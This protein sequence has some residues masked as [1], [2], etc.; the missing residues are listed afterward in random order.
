MRKYDID[1]PDDWDELRIELHCISKGGRWTR[2]N[3][4]EAGL[5][6]FEHLM[7]ARKLAWPDRYR[8]RWTDLLYAEYV[9]NDITIA[10]GAAST[11]KTS[12]ASEFALLNYWARPNNTLVILST[13]SMDKLDTGVFSEVKML[14]QNAHTLYPWLAGNLLESR[15]AITTD[16]VDEGGVRDLRKGII[17]RACYVGGRWVG[18]GVL[19]GTKQ[20]YIIYLADELQFMAETFIASWP[21]LFSNGHVKILGSGNPKHDPD[22]QLGIA[23]EPKEGWTGAQGDITKTDVWDTQF[24]NGRCVNLVGIDSPNLDT[25][26]G[27][28]EP[29]PRLIGRKFLKRMAHDWGE[30]SPEFFTQA[31]GVMKIDMADKRVITRQLCRKQ[32]AQ[33]M[34]VWAGSPRTKIHC[35]DPSYGGGD[36]CISM[37]LEFGAGDNGLSLI[38]VVT[39]RAVL[40]DLR[41]DMSAEDQIAEAVDEDLKAHQ[42]PPENS[43]YDPYGKGTMGFSFAKRFGANC[44]IPVDS[45]GKP[46]ERPVRDDLFVD[47]PSTGERRLKKCSEHY[48]KF[49][50]EAWFSVAYSI[51]AGQMRELPMDVMLEGCARKYEMVAG[52]KIEVESK[53]DYKA[54]AKHSPNKFD[55]LAIGV[56]GARQRGFMIAKLG[57]GREDPADDDWFE[58]EAKEYEEALRKNLLNHT[59]A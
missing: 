2:Q 38:R 44:P 1:W 35:L 31:V 15:R 17:G 3:G 20:D 8:H 27:E 50:T 47:D 24:L 22:D 56:E 59:A 37:V 28:P 6:T 45:G 4:V 53:D 52:N 55:C 30:N 51:H 42:I 19:A 9:K 10:M 12:H 40:I 14:W 54:H 57:P 18:L 49:V 39:F 16:N 13:M 23:A 34:A 32:G 21:N 7:N 43:F 29:Y 58:K 5:G 48:S 36:L 41:R 11:Q 26:E 33:D 46:T 25:P